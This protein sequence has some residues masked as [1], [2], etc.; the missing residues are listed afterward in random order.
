MLVCL[1]STIRSQGFSPSQRF[2]P[3][4]ASW[5]CFTPHPPVGFRPSECFP[6]SQLL[7]LSVPRPLMSLNVT[8][9]TSKLALVIERLFII[10]EKRSIGVVGVVDR[11]RGCRNPFCQ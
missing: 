8:S 2:D 11:L 1:A 9:E 4:R 6:L 7:H 3:T 5:F 10:T